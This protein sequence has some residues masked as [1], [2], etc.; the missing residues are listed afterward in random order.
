[1]SGDEWRAAQE[2]TI[3]AYTHALET[4]QVHDYEQMPLANLAAASLEEWAFGSFVAPFRLLLSSN[5][6]PTISFR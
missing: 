3:A 4:W 1:L 6:P 2:D 5:C